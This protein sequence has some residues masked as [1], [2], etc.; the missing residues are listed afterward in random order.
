MLSA[1]QRQY[2]DLCFQSMVLSKVSCKAADR[3]AI[4]EIQDGEK[5]PR[6]SWLRGGVP[7]GIR[8]KYGP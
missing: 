8:G 3:L 2:S 5:V 4:G 1:L 7:K 6:T